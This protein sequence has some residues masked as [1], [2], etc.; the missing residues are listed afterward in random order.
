MNRS[1][2]GQTIRDA[3]APA[4]EL[5]P[6]SLEALAQA[7]TVTPQLARLYWDPREGLRGR[8][9]VVYPARYAPSEKTRYYTVPYHI[10]W[11]AQKENRMQHLKLIPSGLGL[12]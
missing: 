9:M 12:V 5:S 10:F 1:A 3:H 2:Q 4:P 6:F 8:W 7:A 11:W